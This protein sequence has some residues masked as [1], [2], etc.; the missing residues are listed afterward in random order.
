MKKHRFTRTKKLLH[1]VFRVRQWSDY[2]RVKDSTNYLV[3]GIKKLFVL[4]RPHADTTAKESFDT[5]VK[6]YKLDEQQ[7]TKQ[8]KSLFRLSMLM[9]G[10]ALCAFAYGIYC[11]MYSTWRAVITDFAVTILILIL[12]FRYHFWYFQIKERRLGCSVKQWM[13]QGLL[14]H[15]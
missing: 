6:Q 3:N 14:G 9:L 15:K 8:Q 7:I 10:L 13:K 1:G 2:D 12:A 4:Q 5:A 11:I